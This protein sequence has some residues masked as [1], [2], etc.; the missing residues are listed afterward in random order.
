MGSSH[1]CRCD[2]RPPA[3][4]RGGRGPTGKSGPYVRVADVPAWVCTQCGEE[5][6]DEDV[7]VRLQKLITR[8]PRPLGSVS[9]APP[10]THGKPDAPCCWDETTNLPMPGGRRAPR[11][12]G[13]LGRAAARR[14]HAPAPAGL[15]RA[16][17]IRAGRPTVGGA[18]PVANRR[19]SRL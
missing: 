1:V 15:P 13:A 12:A 6:F 4:T 19:P 5:P 2:M 10:P 3:G 18:A 8:E 9:T 11:R 7:S 14:P 17:G 16:G